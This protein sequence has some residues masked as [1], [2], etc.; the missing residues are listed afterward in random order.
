MAST[1]LE[2][3]RLVAEMER[4]LVEERA[5]RFQAQERLLER[6]AIL[7]EDLT[8]FKDVQQEARLD[9]ELRQQLE[10]RISILATLGDRAETARQRAIRSVLGVQNT[11]TDLDY[12]LGGT[13][14]IKNVN[15]G[16]G[17]GP[18][19]APAGGRDA[20]SGDITS[21]NR[22]GNSSGSSG[23]HHHQLHPN[24]S[25][26]AAIGLAEGASALILTPLE[27][28]E[29]SLMNAEQSFQRLS[30]V[31]IL[32]RN[33]IIELELKKMRKEGKKLLKTSQALM[34][35]VND[36]GRALVEEKRT[37]S[38]RVVGKRP[39]WE[40]E[41]AQLNGTL[42][43]FS[44]ALSLFA[45]SLHFSEKMTDRVELDREKVIAA[46]S[47]TGVASLA[48][49]RS[50]V[51]INISTHQAHRKAGEVL[52]EP[53]PSRGTYSKNVN[54]WGSPTKKGSISMSSS[55]AAAAFIRGSAAGQ[56]HFSGSGGGRSGSTTTTRTFSS[57]HYGL[58]FSSSHTQQI[59]QDPAAVPGGTKPRAIHAG[60]GRSLNTRG[61]GDRNNKPVGHLVLDS[62][63]S[64]RVQQ[65]STL[66]CAQ[67]SNHS[68]RSK[69][70]HKS[71][72][73]G[74][75]IR[76]PS[77]PVLGYDE[78]VAVDVDERAEQLLH[79]QQDRK[80]Q[81]DHRF[82]TGHTGDSDEPSPAPGTGSGNTA[83]TST[84]VGGVL[85]YQDIRNE[86]DVLEAAAQVRS[87]LL[88]QKGN[89]NKNKIPGGSSLSYSATASGTG[90]SASASIVELPPPTAAP[91]TF[92]SRAF[93]PRG[94]FASLDVLGGSVN[95]QT[96]GNSSAS[97]VQTASGQY[98]G[99]G[100]QYQ[101]T[102]AGLTTTSTLMKGSRSFDERIQK[103]LSEVESDIGGRGLAYANSAEILEES[104]NPFSRF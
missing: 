91:T 4:S 2:S 42:Q 16:A 33:K 18:L 37:P 48:S 39:L 11:A 93:D 71:G 40:G 26:S 22:A 6:E 92:I 54:A 84:S 61:G 35:S 65:T 98:N 19:G 89:Y 25:K 81:H 5:L 23:A 44:S 96:T 69:D 100:P 29:R 68:S 49:L 86:D 3:R 12:Y 17:G 66:G 80:I 83:A 76:T 50:E 77:G 102:S 43:N 38:V 70:S 8:L 64:H 56:G 94:A 95:E 82:V 103:L 47:A 97:V 101:P 90:S 63:D 7:E 14:K 28:L 55:S 32:R 24:N 79:G 88:Q 53:D 31:N 1:L 13:V 59:S 57:S 30:D 27:R 20:A 58:P 72:G 99:Q 85:Y 67:T 21:N 15:A 51:G 87:Q 36:L 75:G 46:S 10:D 34:G 104:K 60:G 9:R 41:F 52:K 78:G 73:G 62:Q 74:N 45:E